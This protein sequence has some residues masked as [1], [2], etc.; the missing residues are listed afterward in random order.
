M[1]PSERG[2]FKGDVGKVDAGKITSLLR[3]IEGIE[4]VNNFE[5]TFQ[6]ADDETDEELRLRA[7]AA[8]QSLGKGTI[9][10]LL[11]VA[12]ENDAKVLEISDPNSAGARQNSPGKVS[13]LVETEVPRFPSLVAAMHDVRAAGVQLTVTAKFVFVTPKIV[14]TI[15]SGL[16]GE[17][18][19]KVANE[20]IASLQT[21][22]E[23]LAAG[24][25]AEGAEMLGAIKK[26]ADVGKDTAIVDVKTWRSDVEKPD[27]NPFVQSLIIAV[28]DV[29]PADTAALR[30]A[31]E[32][33][34]QADATV[35]SR[36]D[37]GSLIAVWC[38]RPANQVSRRPGAPPPVT[39]RPASL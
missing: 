13:L 7:K 23:G 3:I 18:K 14:A 31:I 27:S 6:A 4:R 8:L 25:P 19:T 1:F 35:L 26:V 39:L 2:E 38:R 32:G 37:G 36:L 29:N 21:Y 30:T 28:V 12:S 34:V 17:G 5:P 10:A 22:L 24:P 16:T 9:A 33:V 11:R 15:A 20:I